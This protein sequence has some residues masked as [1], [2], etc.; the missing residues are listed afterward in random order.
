[1]LSIKLFTWNT[2]TM[3]G[4]QEKNAKNSIKSKNYP[5]SKTLRKLEKLT[6]TGW[7][8]VI[9]PSEPCSG[10]KS[11]SE[12]MFIDLIQNWPAQLTLK[13]SLVRLQIY[14][15][16]YPRRLSLTHFDLR[17]WRI[18]GRIIMAFEVETNESDF[19]WNRWHRRVITWIWRHLSNSCQ[20]LSPGFLP[21]SVP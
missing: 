3:M 11:T 1:M 16:V 7:H 6:L 5:K 20:N 14:Q 10:R 4:V 9:K 18:R 2:I 19:I 21:E 15:S 17:E 13:L 8:I 12:K